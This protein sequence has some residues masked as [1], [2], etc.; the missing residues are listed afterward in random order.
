ML[1]DRYPSLKGNVKGENY[2][3][4]D[5]LMLLHNV[6]S[7]GQAMSMGLLFFGNF[8]YKVHLVV[9]LWVASAVVGGMVSTGAF[10]GAS[11]IICACMRTVIDY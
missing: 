5:T 3:V 9:G 2:P 6:V 11:K 7:I 10:E 1:E 8:K 4:D